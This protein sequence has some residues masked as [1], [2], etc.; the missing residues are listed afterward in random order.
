[1]NLLNKALPA[2]VGWL[3]TLGSLLIA[4]LG[5]Q[6]LSGVLLALYYSASP[7]SAYASVRYI[8]EELWLGGFLHRL[9]RYGSGFVMVTALLHFARSYFWG[10]YA[11][12]RQWLWVSGMGLGILLTLFA[13]TGQLLPWDQ[14]GY[15]ATVVGIEI[16]ASAPGAGEHVRSFLTGGYGD[17]GSVTLSRFFLLHICL[18]PLAFAALLGAHLWILQRVGSAGGEPDPKNTFYPR[19]LFK[20]TVVTACGALLLVLVAALLPMTDTG[21]GDPSPGG[22]TPRPEWYFLAHYQLL[23]WVPPL[24]GA[25]VLP[26]LL[27]GGLL[28]LPWID[29]NRKIVVGL[30]GAACVALVALTSIGI[31]QLPDEK[32]PSAVTEHARGPELLHHH[33]CMQCHSLAGDGG[34]TG[35]AFDGVGARLQ[36]DY[37]EAWIRNP[38]RFKPTTEMPAFAGGEEELRAIIEH[39]LT[40]ED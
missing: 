21:P 4:Y 26:N 7:E 16:A 38:R 5:F 13:F 15:W 17:I 40:L 28:L 33:E 20:D 36:P 34:T 12:P 30:G 8:D 29:R 6:T 1:M 24:F 14:R 31:A 2:R 32:V 27:L 19:Q 39:L 9:H 35:P 18:L 23:K 25:F 10:A 22:Y 11:K 3:H 37:M